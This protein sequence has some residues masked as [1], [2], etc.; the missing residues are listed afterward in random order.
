M[1]TRTLIGPV[2]KVY[3][4]DYAHTVREMGSRVRGV[5]YDN[6]SV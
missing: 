2:V 4:V 6:F 1:P 5:S 3:A